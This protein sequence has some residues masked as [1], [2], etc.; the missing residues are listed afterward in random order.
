MSKPA[1]LMKSKY[2]ITCVVKSGEATSLKSNK[3]VINEA[4]NTPQPTMI[5]AVRDKKFLPS[6]L[7]KNPIKGSSGIKKT[8]L[9]IS[10]IKK[11][12]KN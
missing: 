8:N 12:Q 7:I 6:P 4:I 9:L 10:T 2:T 5:T 11:Y 3:L 1:V